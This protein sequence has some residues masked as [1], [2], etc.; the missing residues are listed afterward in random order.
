MLRKLIDWFY[1]KEPPQPTADEREEEDLFTA[2]YNET[3]KLNSISKEK[4]QF[5]FL[6]TAFTV[7]LDDVYIIET[8]KIQESRKTA[9]LDEEDKILLLSQ[10]EKITKII[11]AEKDKFPTYAT[12]NCKA[13]LEKI[14]KHIIK[15]DLLFSSHKSTLKGIWLDHNSTTLK[16]MNDYL[17]SV[18]KKLLDLIEKEEL[19]TTIVTRGKEEP[20]KTDDFLVEYEDDAKGEEKRTPVLKF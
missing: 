3:F 15:R 11:K 16:I 1:V 4:I 14:T 18:K 10:R 2:N 19:A 12:A 17:L 5:I 13:E 9:D 6:N 20:P 7:A 8:A